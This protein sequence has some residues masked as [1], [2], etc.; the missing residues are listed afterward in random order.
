[1]SQDLEESFESNR[2]GSNSDGSS[3]GSDSDSDGST[4][5]SS[6]G[7]SSSSNSSNPSRQS[8]QS[9][10]N[11]N[12]PNP[13]ANN[14]SG[15]SSLNQS[16]SS[17]KHSSSEESGTDGSQSS[18]DDSSDNE[19]EQQN[20]S[21]ASSAND[22]NESDNAENEGNQE[23]DSKSSDDDDESYQVTKRNTR[24]RKA[25]QPPK[26]TAANNRRRKKWDETSDEESASMEPSN[27]EDEQYSDHNRRP[28]RQVAVATKK[29]QAKRKAARKKNY[30]S[31]SDS[32]D[33]PKRSATRR[34]A[35]AVSYK[36][37]SEDEK[38]DSEDLIDVDYDESSVLAT[39]EESDKSETIERVIQRRKGKRG[40]TG[41]K[42]TIYASEEQNGVA[43]DSQAD[44]KTVSSSKQNGEIEEQYLIKWKGWSYIH[45]TWESEETIREQKVKGIK[46]LENYIKKERD[47]E[48]WRKY[49]N[50]EDIDYYECQLELQQDLLKSYNNVERIIAESQKPDGAL[51]YLCKWESLPYS[52][53]TWEDSSLVLRHWPEKIQD[54]NRREESNQTPSR[55]SRVIKYRP[56]FQQ[57]KKQPEYMG[58][59]RGLKLRD[60]QMDGLNWLILTWCKENS[61]ILADEMG[62][63]KTI[64]TIC[65]LN[66]LFKSQS[67]HGPFLCVVPLSTMTAW[68]R[69][70][71]IWAPEM[72]IITYL[73]DVQSRE[74]IRQYEWC[75]AS[76]NRLKFNAILTTYEIL[77]KDKA[78]LGCVS[79]AALLV[80]EAHRLKNDDS[81]LYKAL[82]EFETNHR[83]LITGTPLQN[84]LKELWAL[85]HFIM[86]T[87]FTSWQEFEEKHENAAEKGYTGLHKQ[88]EPYILRRVKKDVEKSLPAKVEQILRVEMTSIQ[89]QY[90][91]WILT[92]NFNALRKGSKGSSSTFLNIVIEL[93]KCCNHASLIRQNELEQAYHHGD[94]LQMLLK[95]S[96]KLVLLDKLLCRLKETGHRVLIFSQMVR[97][98]D[99]LAEYLQKRHFTFQRLDGSIK[100]EIRKQALDHFN[101]EG[102][103]D[104]CFLLSTRAGGL[105]INLATA[106]T[107]IIFDS[108]W[109]PQNDLQAQARAHRIGQ[110]NQVNIYRLVTARSVEEDIVERAKQKMVLDHLVIQR[111]DTTGRTV[112]DKNSSS[113]STPFNKEDLSA[114]LKFGAEELFKDEAEGDGDDLICDI[115]EILRRA[116]T[117]DEAPTMVGDELL[118]AFKVASFA[119]FD[120]DAEESVVSPSTKSAYNKLS[121][122]NDAINEG[123][124]SQDWDE[125]I[126]EHIRRK[127]EEEE[128]NKEMEDLY[129]PPRNR[130]TLQQINQQADGGNEK[131]GKKRKK[132]KSDDDSDNESAAG[133]DEDRPKKRGR[134]SL[135]EK[136]CNFTDAELRKFIK[137]YKK[138]PVPL[139]RLDAIALDAELQEKPLTDL[140]KIGEM[141]R[142]RCVK[143][144]AEHKEQPQ[145]DKKAAKA[146]AAEED[147]EGGKKKG[148][149]AGFSIKFG[150]VSFNAKTLM[151]CEEELAPLDQVIP[152]DATERSKWIFDI[153]TRPAN[154]DV[155]WTTEDDSRLLRGI[156][157]YGI[158]SWESM[159]MD[160]SLNLSEKILANDSNKKPQGKHLQSRAEYLLKIIRK[161]LELT[162]GMNKGKGKKP[163]KP[164]EPKPAKSK[165]IIENENISSADD[166]KKKKEHHHHHHTPIV[167]AHEN[168]NSNDR[169]ALN[170]S[171]PHNHQTAQNIPNS[172]DEVSNG[173]ATKETAKNSTKKTKANK[174][175]KKNKTKVD[176]P[177]HFTANNEP[178][179]LDVL[180]GLDPS[181]FNECKEKMRPV[182]KALKALDNPDQ[183]LS[184]ADQVSHTRECLV[185]IGKQIELCLAEYKEQDKIKEWRSNLWHFVSKFTEFDAKK[186]FKLYRHAVKRAE[187]ESDAKSTTTTSPA[188]NSK[189]LAKDSK[190]GHDHKD[191]S[192]QSLDEK[193][194]R[195]EKKRMQREK[196]RREK[197]EHNR[198]RQ[199]DTNNTMDNGLHKDDS[200]KRRLEEGE[201]V[202]DTPT[203]SYKRQ[204]PDNRSGRSGKEER[205]R[206]DSNDHEHGRVRHNSGSHSQPINPSHLPNAQR[207]P[208]NYDGRDRS[209]YNSGDAERWRDNRYN[210]HKRFDAYNRGTPHGY[211][212]RDNRDHRD[213][214][215]DRDRRGIDNKRRYQQPPMGY[216]SNHYIS[217]N[218]PYYPPDA[219]SIPANSSNA[220]PYRYPP[221][222][223]SSSEWR[224]REQEFDNY[225]REY[226]RRAPPPPSGTS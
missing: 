131:R 142:D 182:K 132:Q 180:G 20:N 147:G 127:V 23:A 79:W 141:L 203:K 190:S 72:N 70:F 84:S 168:N 115:D 12:V 16:K 185:R 184:N 39:Q 10:A 87:K 22:T 101:A 90:Y 212:S 1:M 13:I 159:K 110:K 122:G 199:D 66:Y 94:A 117:R 88:L 103:Q 163:R 170:Q 76:T 158:G 198:H 109:N 145:P 71:C 135:K 55:H 44:V 102:S 126:P 11:A 137:S 67:L 64:Q 176:G 213:R 153:K 183:S 165:D 169:T 83:L 128:R 225:R 174:E 47:I 216:P 37:A 35:A 113:T 97:M 40:D 149:R 120:E 116:E 138:F 164:K 201:L 59:D 192:N 26:R 45:C 175:Q 219:A 38:T 140:K 191:K 15:G 143:F 157:Q 171:Q 194:Q 123:E 124:T 43:S 146:A 162:K 121:K 119:A 41:N 222:N 68:Q 9:N 2:D 62:L 220:A 34:A 226:D 19:N 150:G 187:D 8:R 106:D 188:K 33:D 193:Q 60:Y 197:E 61:V 30:S 118:S 31:D 179:A 78:F 112:L 54:F 82:Y 209:M 205:S 4:S 206:W 42:T 48:H 96:G 167:A 56:K 46:K 181:V 51:D 207:V 152:S 125:I 69:E 202:E 63:G 177:M 24:P 155:E 223:S 93:K 58:E 204:H 144:L 91:K 77:L 200:G 211:H 73:G 129:L 98:L 95:G 166:E 208:Q 86:P 154:F 28:R 136:F 156:Y 53:A 52:E 80:D 111:M 100:G 74:I 5:S 89:K 218:A 107:V 104:F 25:P 108:D 217:H 221:G 57:L 224:S 29:Q 18:S 6:S 173:S 196:E 81:L 65:F 210:D 92:K 133:S 21:N 32:D 14:S 215:R 75:F 172:H 99:I 161:N 134:P 151:A 114:I 36:E 189:D 105:G 17:T 3:S 214:D 130:K 139:K 50:V 195:K 49:A 7:S 27:S 178:R 148:V 186:L 85:L 160:P